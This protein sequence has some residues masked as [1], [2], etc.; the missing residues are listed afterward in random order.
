VGESGCVRDFSAASWVNNLT[1]MGRFGAAEPPRSNSIFEKKM[2]AAM[3]MS[4]QISEMTW[5][6]TL[7]DRIIKAKK[8]DV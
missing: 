6:F 5:P 7:R 8:R 4:V 3:R 2:F 1:N